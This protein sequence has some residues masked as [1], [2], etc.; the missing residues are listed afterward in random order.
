MYK[1][2][3]DFLGSFIIKS[4]FLGLFAILFSVF[5]WIPNL[6]AKG[7][8]GS[9]K[10]GFVNIQEVMNSSTQ[11]KRVKAELGKLFKKKKKELSATE[12]D[13]KTMREDL[14]KKKSV[15]SDAVLAQKQRSWE[16][17]MLAYRKQLSETD[18]QLRKRE[19][20]LAGPV[21]K[22]VNTIINEIG[23]KDSY[24]VILQRSPLS[25]NLLWAAEEINLTPRV[26]R[27]LEKS[28]K[29]R[30]KK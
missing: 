27:E 3:R 1:F 24:T 15:L 26:I 11:G 10:I 12:Q 19:R 28:K 8:K 9:I 18:L 13:L 22:N 14:E 2:K 21:L 29:K 30:S 25:N 5:L 4:V 6:F 23:K 16:I 20:D 7:D 17:K